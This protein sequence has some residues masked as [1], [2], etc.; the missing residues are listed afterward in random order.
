MN[1][2]NKWLVAF[3]AIALAAGVWLGEPL[4]QAED[5][6][7]IAVTSSTGQPTVILYGTSWCPYCRQTRKFFAANGIQY[8]DLDIEKS[9]EAGQ[10]YKKLRGIA[11]PVIVIGD[12]VFRGFSEESLRDALGPWLKGRGLSRDGPDVRAELQARATSVRLAAPEPRERRV[13][14]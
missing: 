10:Q 2:R 14:S 11:V 12:R 7:V 13:R 3:G 6:E 5:P 1:N 4:W 9:W 8:T